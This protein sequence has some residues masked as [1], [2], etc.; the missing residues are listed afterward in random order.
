[1]YFCQKTE[2]TSIKDWSSLVKISHLIFSLPFAFIGFGL[3]YVSFAQN[4]DFYLLLYVFLAV[5]F[6]RN[7]AMAFNRIVDKEFDARNERTKNREI[8]ARKIK[9]TSALAFVGLN[10]VLFILVTFF[11]NPLCF[12]LSFVALAVIL[13][14]SYSKRFT[15]LSHYL[16]GMSLAIAPMG[17]YLTLSG[18][19]DLVPILISFA[20][21]FWVSGFDILYS[22][23]DEEFDREQNLHSVPARFGRKKAL[24][25]ARIGHLFSVL[26]LLAVAI[27][28]DAGIWNYIGLI[29]FS[30]ILLY[31]H[32]IVKV[33]DISRVN[34]AFAFLNGMA[35]IVYATFFL[36][37][38]FVFYI[39]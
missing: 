31:E 20:V 6:A 37:D 1:M 18:T 38:L 26:M 17:A 25:I 19:F 30:A 11:I 28:M 27:L 15:Y 22:L 32:S 3:A 24:I 8:P 23:Q 39:F 10:S 13:G 36:F 16:L 12:Y 9:H 2:M 35:G 21:L 7:A 14:Y 4:F 29:L 33:H 34:F 5:F